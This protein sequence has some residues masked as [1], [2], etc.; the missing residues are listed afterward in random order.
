[1]TI[2]FMGED[3]TALVVGGWLLVGAGLLGCW[4][5]GLLGEIFQA[6][7]AQDFSQHFATRSPSHA[8]TQPLSNP[9]TDSNFCFAPTIAIE[10][11]GT[12]VARFIESFS[13]ACFD[14]PQHS[15]EWF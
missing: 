12:S 9:A 3:C 8:E 14:A 5:A 13:P 11:R 6:E 10:S 4:V 2:A 15:S 7:R 1:M